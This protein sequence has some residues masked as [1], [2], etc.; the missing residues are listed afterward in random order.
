[1]FHVPRWRYVLSALIDFLAHM[2]HQRAQLTTAHNVFAPKLVG[3]GQVL[4]HQ[5]ADLCHLPQEI[6]VEL[7]DI[8]SVLHCVRKEPTARWAIV[9]NVAVVS[10]GKSKQNANTT[11]KRET[12]LNPVNAPKERELKKTNGSP[13][14]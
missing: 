14:G 11:T 9:G 4:G 10:H 13:A 7:G 5:A 8:Y 1:M 2:G 3:C 6:G 12:P